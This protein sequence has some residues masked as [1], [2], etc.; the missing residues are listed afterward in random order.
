MKNQSSMKSFWQSF[1]QPLAEYDSDN[2]LNLTRVLE[3][4][5]LAGGDYSVI[6]QELYIHE[7]T[8][9]YRVNKMHELLNYNNSNDFYADAKAA[10]YMNWI[11]YDETLSRLA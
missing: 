2:K 10:V 7:T 9:R 6:A 1:Y 3:L 4:Y 8:V 5:V 11:F